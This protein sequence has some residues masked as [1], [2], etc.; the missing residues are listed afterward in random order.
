MYVADSFNQTI[1]RITPAGDVTTFA[2]AS[3]ITGSTDGEGSA[4]R[5]ER[6]SS[7]ATD[8]GGNLYVTDAGGTIR[9]ITPGAVVTTVAGVAGKLGL[10]D[11]TGPVARF[12]L[13]AG[14]A[15]GSD[16]RV[17]VADGWHVIRLGVPALPDAATI[18][19]RGGPLDVPRQLD[20]APQ[21][22]TEWTWSILRRPSG[23]SNEL[24][25]PSIRNPTFVPDAL[26][27]FTFRL[28]ATAASVPSITTVDLSVPVAFGPPENLTATAIDTW[29]VALSWSPV[30]GATGYE[31]YRSAAGGA[32]V[33]HNLVLNTPTPT[34]T[35]L[36]TRPTST[37]SARSTTTAPPPSARSPP[38]P[39]PSSPITP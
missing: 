15:V 11:G 10:N 25:D 8:A 38:R 21:T 26:G 24:S 20:T 22:A 32:F 14:I 27:L 34:S 12:T 30:S 4:A 7:I 28:V 2:G 1:R 31:I 6:P 9:K 33:F 23:S 13:P 3:G 19:A 16:G 35:P 37:K 5:F 39:P 36:R 29:K 17:Y 18:D